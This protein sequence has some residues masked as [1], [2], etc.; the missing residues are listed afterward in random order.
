MASTPRR[1]Q[2][3]HSPSKGRL[4]STH[5]LRGDSR[6]IPGKNHRSG[7][8]TERQRLTLLVQTNTPRRTRSHDRGTR[9]AQGL[10]TRRPEINFCR[11][12][13]PPVSTSRRPRPTRRFAVTLSTKFLWRCRGPEPLTS[14]APEENH[15]G[16][17]LWHFEKFLWRS[18]GPEPLIQG[19]AGQEVPQWIA[20]PLCPLSYGAAGAEK[21][22]RERVQSS[23]LK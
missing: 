7:T 22:F 12:P 18:R 14:H 23:T 1:H 21:N 17:S 2:R 6:R 19:Q 3:I 16:E 8:S 15:P 4:G 9:L 11:A 13:E 10:L 5:P 20:E